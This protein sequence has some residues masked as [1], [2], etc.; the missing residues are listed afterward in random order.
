MDLF[1]KVENRYIPLHAI[2]YV[3]DDGERVLVTLQHVK[4]GPGELRLEGAE[5]DRLRSWLEEHTA[6]SLAS[7]SEP[8]DTGYRSDD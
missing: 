5:A 2:A 3:D 1:I 7:E 8:Q 6:V 4:T